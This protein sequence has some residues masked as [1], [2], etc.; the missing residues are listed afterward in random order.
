MKFF[1][2]G[3]ESKIHIDVLRKCGVKNYLTSFFYIKKWGFNTNENVMLDSGGFTARTK[4]KEIKIKNYIDFINNNN[5]KLAVNLDTNNVKETLSNQKLLEKETKAYILPV[6]H[7]SDYKDLKYRTLIDKYIEKY[8]FICVGGMAGGANKRNHVEIFLNYVFNKTRD[9]IKIH[10][11]GLTGD[12][13]LKK[14]PLFSVDST[15][16]QQFSRYGNSRFINDEKIKKLYLK[17]RNYKERDKIEIKG[18][19]KKEKYYTDLWKKRGI[20]WRKDL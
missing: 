9:K 11:L 20:I 13:F 1:F 17:N 15:S 19:L 14:Y 2:A 16:W 12:Y 10:G 8:N 3:T 4:G 7:L 18:T 6:Y 5:V